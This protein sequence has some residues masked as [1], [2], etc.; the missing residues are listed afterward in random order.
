MFYTGAPQN[1][2]RVSIDNNLTKQAFE[3]M[4]ENSIDIKNIVVHAPY[5]VNLANKTN[6]NFNVSFM[7]EEIKRTEAL[8]VSMITIH[9][10]SHVNLGKE[11]GLKNI[12][13][14][15]NKIITKD[16]KVLVL[17]ESMSGMGSEL[18]SSFEELKYI[19]DNVK[20]KIGVCLDTCHIFNAGYDIN[21]FLDEFDKIIGLEYLKCVHINDS[22]NIIG[23]KKDRHENLGF[24]HIG[25]DTL[26]NLIYNPKLKDVPKILETP[27]VT[28]ND[29]TKERIYPPYE[30]EIAMIKNRK[31]N[32]N[33]ITEIRDNDS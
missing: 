5:I 20:E 13:E 22:K 2:T 15:L 14:S 23:S 17:L 27:Y 32:E 8:G 33:L 24:G 18:G 31:F 30:K 7:K 26:I 28:L 16:Q 1:T 12:V 4:K 3:L 29:N 11:I 10:G 9:P 21:N 19:I 25:F 6:M